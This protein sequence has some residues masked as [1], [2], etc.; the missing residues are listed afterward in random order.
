MPNETLLRHSVFARDFSV[1]TRNALLRRGV[2]VIGTCT[3]PAASG[4]MRM[5][6]GTRG[7]ELSDDGMFCI[8]THAEVVAMAEREEVSS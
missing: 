6:N 1:K 8:R 3:I 4:E 2:A 5:A 7:Y